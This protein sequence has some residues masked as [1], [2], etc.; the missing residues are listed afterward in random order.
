MEGGCETCLML[1]SEPGSAGG[2]RLGHCHRPFPWPPYEYPPF[3]FG[4][5]YRGSEQ[6]WLQEAPAI[7]KRRGQAVVVES[8][9]STRPTSSASRTSAWRQKRLRGSRLDRR[10]PC[11]TDYVRYA[12]PASLQA[13]TSTDRHGTSM[14]ARSFASTVVRSPFARVHKVHST[15][16][17]DAR[18]EHIIWLHWPSS[19]APFLA[20]F[21]FLLPFL[22]FFFFSYLALVPS[23]LSAHPASR[24]FLNTKD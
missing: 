23:P 21:F 4:F 18:S 9:G 12:P 2:S 10:D 1:R 15:Q 6:V 14:C 20:S 19:P 22:S 8:T 24:T 7:G 17:S 16:I 11:A 3:R 5:G 13:S